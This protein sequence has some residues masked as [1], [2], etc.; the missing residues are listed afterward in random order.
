MHGLGFL[1]CILTVLQ[2]GRDFDPYDILANVIGS[3]GALA[4]CSVYHRRMLERRRAAKTYNLV[5]GEDDVDVEL[6]ESRQDESQ[7]TGVV[8]THQST[9]TEELDNW[10]ENAEDWDEDDTAAESGNDVNGKGE[11]GHK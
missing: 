7:E 3:G 4:I 10:D 5:P 11:N 6:G 9:V 2:N 8:P 1:S